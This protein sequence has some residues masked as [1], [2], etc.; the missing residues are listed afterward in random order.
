MVLPG[1]RPFWHPHSIV[2]AGLAILGL[3]VAC[4]Q[5]I[6]EMGTARGRQLG[7]RAKWNY[8][9]EVPGE[10][11]LFPPRNAS[12]TY[13]HVCTKGT[14][15]SDGEKR[16]AAKQLAIESFSCHTNTTTAPS[17]NINLGYLDIIPFIAF[18]IYGGAHLFMLKLL[19]RMFDRYK[20]A[21]A[22]QAP[23]EIA[24][25]FFKEVL[26]NVIL[27]HVLQSCIL[28]AVN[29]VACDGT[30]NDFPI[31]LGGVKLFVA[32]LVFDTYQYFA[33]R[34]CHRSP[35]FRWMHAQHHKIMQAN[36]FGA[37]YGHLFDGLFIDG[38][39]GILATTIPQLTPLENSIFLSIATM[40]G[41]HDHC[42]VEY[43]W[44]PFT[45]FGRVTG[46]TAEFHWRHHVHPG[47]NF[48]VNFFIFW[49]RL[50]G[51]LYDQRPIG[52]K[53]SL[54]KR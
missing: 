4:G 39:A 20:I 25:D 32:M 48:Q 23:I 21:A 49:D 54:G 46:N 7:K 8:N 45:W 19:P 24:D 2:L 41:V 11:Y 31:I 43:P 53:L 16:T 36:G 15:A 47:C 9:P 14:L 22:A 44:D 13:Q 35:K 50:F 1:H 5:V 27:T 40:K 33:H 26:A 34:A 30:H 29:G 28:A 37:Q 38:I 52:A 6:E 51:T 3:Q 17:T 10:Q 12:H 18:W 42:C